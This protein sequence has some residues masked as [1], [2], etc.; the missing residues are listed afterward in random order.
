MIT[1]SDWDGFLI[2]DIKALAQDFL[3]F[4]GLYQN[5]PKGY[6][7][8]AAKPD[9]TQTMTALAQ[10]VGNNKSALEDPA[11]GIPNGTESQCSTFR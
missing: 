6:K 5:A 11:T 2:P 3:E 9:S 8:M 4:V 7:E 10:L 1:P